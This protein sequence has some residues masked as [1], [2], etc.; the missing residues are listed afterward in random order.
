M[1]AA[2][3]WSENIEAT[4]SCRLLCRYWFC[5]EGGWQYNVPVKFEY[6]PIYLVEWELF[7]KNT[8]LLWLPLFHEKTDCNCYLTCSYLEHCVKSSLFNICLFL[9]RFISMETHW[10]TVESSLSNFV[11][12][13]IV[14]FGCGDPDEWSE[15]VK[16]LYILV[17][18]KV[19]YKAKLQRWGELHWIE[20]CS[21]LQ[22]VW[23]SCP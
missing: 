3:A 9:S 2:K 7:A 20:V 5:A 13:T 22:R 17:H 16:L 11:R 4:N 19:D 18:T 10:T 14:P 12:E 1:W 6:V 23:E 8:K 21:D 15:L